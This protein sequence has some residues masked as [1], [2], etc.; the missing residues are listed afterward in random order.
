MNPSYLWARALSALLELAWWDKPDDELRWLAA[1]F[2]S[3]EAMLAE[4]GLL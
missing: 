4:E 3:P 1:R 2:D